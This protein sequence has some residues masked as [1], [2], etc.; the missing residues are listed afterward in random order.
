[1]G[2]E[3]LDNPAGLVNIPSG[4]LVFLG[5]LIGYVHGVLMEDIF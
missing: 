5:V 2:K 1:M 4:T 3:G